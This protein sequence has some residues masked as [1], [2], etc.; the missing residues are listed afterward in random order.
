MKFICLYRNLLILRY[1]GGLIRAMTF[2][3]RTEQILNTLPNVH[4][5]GVTAARKS[6]EVQDEAAAK[7][8]YYRHHGD[9]Y[10]AVSRGMEDCV[11]FS[12]NAIINV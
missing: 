11:M 10:S 4:T 8:T 12:I 5:V 6:T 3:I 9:F 2:A 7:M 1:P